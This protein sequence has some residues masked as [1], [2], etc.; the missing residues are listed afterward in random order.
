MITLTLFHPH[1]SVP[2]QS[3]TFEEETIVRIGR[4]TDNHIVLYSAVVSRYHVELR[5]VETGWK[6]V[7][8]GTN[9][10]YVDDQSIT[11]VPAT[12]GTIFRL[13][14]SGPQMLVGFSN[15]KQK[16][17]IKTNIEEIGYKSFTP[18]KVN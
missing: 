15:Q 5:Q 12:D 4:A 14:R 3:W 7:N 9:G 16:P 6:I 13:A 18:K 10:T 1:Q 17:G 11:Q 2:P 8:I